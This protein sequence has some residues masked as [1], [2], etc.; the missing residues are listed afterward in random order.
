ML[1]RLL[2]LFALAI[3][4]SSLPAHRGMADICVLPRGTIVD[5]DKGLL[6][7]FNGT[8]TIN[9]E[10]RATIR[11]QGH[12]WPSFATLA[13]AKRYSPG[14]GGSPGSVQP[15]GKCGVAPRPQAPKAAGSAPA[16]KPASIPQTR[17]TFDC[18]KNGAV[19]YTVPGTGECFNFRTMADGSMFEF[20]GYKYIW[21]S[22]QTAYRSLEDYMAEHR[23]LGLAKPIAAAAPRPSEPVGGQG[24]ATSGNT[25]KASSGS[26]LIESSKSCVLTDQNGRP[27]IKEDEHIVNEEGTST[28]YFRNDCGGKAIGVYASTSRGSD[29][30]QWTAVR[31]YGRD[32][33]VCYKCQFTGYRVDCK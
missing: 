21:Q 23:Q 13:D 1:V 3:G 5:T 11:E 22:E 2:V 4:A 8:T 25:S 9:E 19:V 32:R 10:A 24:T 30:D 6:Y 28:L 15:I 27:C 20:Q 17:A 12:Q 7:L 31:P 18:R 33:L 29:K 16:R 26:K 14:F